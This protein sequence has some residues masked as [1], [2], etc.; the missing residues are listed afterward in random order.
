MQVARFFIC[1]N[2]GA[3]YEGNI[4]GELSDSYDDTIEL[5]HSTEFDEYLPKPDQFA[6]WAK[7]N[8]VHVENC[9]SCENAH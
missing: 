4:D 7:S 3:H 6:V 2:C 1:P 9:G 8:N 5:V